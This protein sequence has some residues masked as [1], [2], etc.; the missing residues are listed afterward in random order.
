MKI[1]IDLPT[2]DLTLARVRRRI[3]ESLAELRTT[4]TVEVL[5]DFRVAVYVRLTPLATVQHDSADWAAVRQPIE[6][7]VD[8]DNYIAPYLRAAREAA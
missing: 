3:D 8:P 5:K 6:M 7:L 4:G 2:D 1:E